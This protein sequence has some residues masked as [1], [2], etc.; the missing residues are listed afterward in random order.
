MGPD[1][2]RLWVS[3]QDFRNDIIVSERRSRSGGNLS[4]F[5]QRAPLPLFKPYD[6]DPAR[7]AV[8]RS[9]SPRWT[10]DSGRVLAAENRGHAAYDRYEFQVVY[11]KLSQF[12]RSSFRKFITMW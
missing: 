8:P 10:V 2:V 7:D 11:Q 12:V 9:S 5:A 1:I 4:Q 6:F 3:S